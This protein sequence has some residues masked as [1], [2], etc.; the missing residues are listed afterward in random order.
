MKPAHTDGALAV[1]LAAH[2]LNNLCTALLGF[3]DLARNIA[4]P[5]SLLDSYLREVIASG[6]DAVV[7]AERLQQIALELRRTAVP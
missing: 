2:D 7:V 5:G 3:A 4:E 1:E 6:T